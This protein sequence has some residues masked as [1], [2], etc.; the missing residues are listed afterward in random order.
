[1]SNP[2]DRQVNDNDYYSGK[3]IQP[4]QYATANGFGYC[5]SL[6]LKYLTRHR[7]KNGAE[8]LHKAIHCLEMLIELEY[9]QAEKPAAKRE[10]TELEKPFNPDSQPPTRTLLHTIQECKDR[11]ELDSERHTVGDLLDAIAFDSNAAA[12]TEIQKYLFAHQHL[13]RSTKLGPFFS[14]MTEGPECKSCGG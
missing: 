1:M 4:V 7:Q 14:V 3:A 8:D 9:T 5:E 13:S 10:P 2:L 6:A 11:H 12:L